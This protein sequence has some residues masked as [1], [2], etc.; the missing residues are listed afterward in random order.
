MTI[1]GVVTI[2]YHQNDVNG[3]FVIVDL[4]P[5]HLLVMSLLSRA[6]TDQSL[7]CGGLRYSLSSLGKVEGEEVDGKYLATRFYR[8]IMRS[9][10][11]TV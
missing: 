8:L 6:T 1:V 2:S 11:R 4:F 5:S 7:A 9:N 3:V 10:F